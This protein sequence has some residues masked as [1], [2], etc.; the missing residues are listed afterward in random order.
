[1]K[2]LSGWRPYVIA[3]VLIGALLALYFAVRSSN[4][5]FGDPDEIEQIK[6]STD[7]GELQRISDQALNDMADHRSDRSFDQAVGYSNAASDRMKQLN[8]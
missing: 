3:F 1:M 6:S 8:C 2:L 7:C 5:R 4:D